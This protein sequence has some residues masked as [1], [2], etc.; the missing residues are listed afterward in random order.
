MSAGKRKRKPAPATSPAAPAST[1]AV[2][3]LNVRE[4][5]GGASF[6]LRVQPRAARSAVVGVHAGALKLSLTAAPVDGGAN[7]ALLRLLAGWLD[8]RRAQLELL[9]GEHSR[10]KVVHVAGLNAADLRAKLS[11]RLG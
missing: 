3:Q 7:D 5:D 2:L 4:H 10:A 11:R 1:D 6:E 9:R 8:V